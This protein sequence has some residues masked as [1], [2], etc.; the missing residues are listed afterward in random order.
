[1][2]Y[3]ETDMP[4]VY[5]A[6]RAFQPGVLEMWLE[7]IT[8]RLPARGAIRDLI[9]VGCGTGRFTGPLA[10][11]C[12]ATALGIDPSEK[13][14]AIARQKH[15][16]A[17][18]SFRRGPAEDLPAGDASADLVFLSM[19]FHH[20]AD[21]T[22]ALREC[23]RVLRP[24]G[25]VCVRNST[26]EQRSP[27]AQFFPGYQEIAD[28]VLPSAGDIGSSFEQAGFRLR[29]H[30]LVAH[31]MAPN[32]MAL[33]EK[34]AM[35]ADSILVRLPHASFVEGVLAMRAQA[36]SAPDEFVGMNIDLFVFAK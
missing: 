9:D 11:L 27:Y 20:F 8:A 33:A 30:D 28:Q 17:S 32:W 26:A 16:A 7:R 18:V 22:K 25:L 10:K 31:Q 21:R 23:R 36:P 29:S 2:D 12:A 34:A 5:D 1:M 24:H 35:R 19:S 15:H 4:A 3:D 14:L 6:A 13:M